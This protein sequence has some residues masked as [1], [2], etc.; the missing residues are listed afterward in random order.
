[1]ISFRNFSIRSKLLVIVLSSVFASLII[2]S[3]A[4]VLINHKV[5]TQEFKDQLQILVD[6]TSERSKAALAFKDKRVLDSNLKNLSRLESIDLAC[7]YDNESRL[8]ASYSSAND[9]RQCSNLSL[10]QTLNTQNNNI[11]VTADIT[12]KNNVIGALYVHANTNHLDSRLW[13]FVTYATMIMLFSGMVAYFMAL[14]LQRRVILPII[15]LSNVSK[16]IGETH[17]F[18]L[19]AP[20]YSNDE[21]GTL[22]KAFNGLINNIQGSQ[23]QMEELVLELQEKTR[24]LESHTELVED[25]NKV[26]RNT[27]AGASHD[28]RQPLQA[29]ALFVDALKNTAQHSQVD[30]L[31]KLDMAIQNMRK[32]FDELLDVSKLESHLE[33]VQHGPVELKPLL[34]GVFHE[35]EALAQDK[36]IQLRFHSRDYLVDSNASMLERII[37]NLLSNAIRYTNNGG[38]LLACRK[39]PD[40]VL[41]EIW[42]TGLGIPEESMNSVFKQFYQVERK[43]PEGQ[44]GYGL[45]LSIVRRLSALLK[46]PIEIKSKVGQGSLFRVRVP[47]YYDGRTSAAPTQIGLP[48]VHAVES[49]AELPGDKTRV[50]L[51]DDDDLVREGLTHLIE[52]W[53]MPVLA[54]GSISEMECYLSSNDAVDVDIIVSDFQLSDTETGIDAIKRAKKY[55]GEDTPALIVTGTKDPELLNNIKEAGLRKLPKPVKAAKLRALINHLISENSR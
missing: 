38:V 21:V 20:V 34:D 12:L 25:R 5:A 54:F 4:I 1:M 13:E 7:L 37:R 31:S 48:P 10:K 33:K 47:I 8:F 28:L 45:G 26:I 15:S 55:I 22:A 50:L 35:F 30:L 42:D 16:R 3:S 36:S 9:N 19:R 2:A 17:N 14:R 51:I 40:H 18:S 27:F 41:V 11:L 43:H 53:R 39:R 44:Q 6:I 24:Q 46:H 29:M 32:L 49:L 52:G 23:I